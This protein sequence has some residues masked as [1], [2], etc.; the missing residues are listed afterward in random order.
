[1]SCKRIGVLC[2]L[3]FGFALGLG[4]TAGQARADN[5][6]F[7]GQ[8][9]PQWQQATPSGQGPL[10]LAHA[11]DA[12]VAAPTRSGAMLESELKARLGPINAALYLQQ[13]RPEGGPASSRASVHELYAS[14]EAL[15]WQFSAGR[16]QVSWDVGYAF[17]PNDMVAQE[18]RLTLLSNMPPGR[19]LLQAEFFTADT[20]WSLVWVNPQAGGR[21]RYG[22]EQAAALRVYQRQGS[23][24][25]HGFA[26]WGQATGAGLGAAL[27]WVASDSLELHASARLSQRS[28]VWRMR[29]DGIDLS[30]LQRSNPWTAQQLQS[31]GQALLG[32]NWTGESRLGLLIEAWWD[33]KA[34]SAA[35]WSDWSTRNQAL[36]DLSARAPAAAAAGNLAW[37]ASAFSNASLHRR[38]IF[39]RASWE[40]EGWQ[41]TLDLL[42]M[43]EDGGS[44]VTAA[45][46]WA[47][48]RG[49]FDAGLRVF[50][51]FGGPA[52]AVAAQLPQRRLAYA[53]ATWSF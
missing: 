30:G 9:R 52:N 4:I 11:L 3:G 46:A 47:G 6:E 8:L 7:S 12:T 37:Q 42:Y 10:A 39:L 35:Q 28:E 45:L 1:M 25:W 5:T 40:H 17:R 2:G 18:E 43:P 19:P 22:D 49:R 50:G 24:D 44:I 27:A 33:G 16:K 14:G 51:G 34:L 15:G 31:T 13:S 48:D 21:G 36:A 26:R 32:L 41:P 20:A 23:A 29:V 53:A 38:N